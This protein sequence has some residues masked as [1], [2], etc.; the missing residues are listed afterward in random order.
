MDH[1]HFTTCKTQTSW[2]WESH[3]NYLDGHNSR[4]L[5]GDLC[6]YIIAKWSTMWPNKGR[7]CS[8]LL[9]LRCGAKGAQVFSRV[10]QGTAPPPCAPRAAARARQMHSGLLTSIF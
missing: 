6:P 3:S 2:E 10:I 8:F 5:N 9:S 1:H 7:K 4:Y